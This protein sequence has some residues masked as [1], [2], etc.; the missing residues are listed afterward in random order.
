MLK[1]H[2]A[3]VRCFK[4]PLKR[5]AERTPELVSQVPEYALDTLAEQSMKEVRNGSKGPS[6]FVEI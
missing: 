1:T 5:K 3:R 6:T 2:K 4:A